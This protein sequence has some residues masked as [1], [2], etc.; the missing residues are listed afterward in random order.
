MNEVFIDISRLL[1]PWEGVQVHVVHS[2]PQHKDNQSV[3]LLEKERKK[4][5][6]I[7]HLKT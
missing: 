3:C 6:K 7:P 1:S 2:L 5:K 4:G